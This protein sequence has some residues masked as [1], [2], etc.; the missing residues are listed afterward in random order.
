MDQKIKTTKKKM[1][2]NLNVTSLAT[3]FT[4]VLVTVLAGAMY[5]RKPFHIY[6]EQMRQEHHFLALPAWTYKIV[7]PLLIALDVSSLFLYFSYNYETCAQTYYIVA[8]AFALATLFGYMLWPIV[9]VKWGSATGGFLVLFW[10]FASASVVFGMMI[11]SM[12][13]TGCPAVSTV[14]PTGAI[15]TAFWG[16]Q[17][18]ETGPPGPK[19]GRAQVEK[20]T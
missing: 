3:W 9:F 2:S 1:W 7:W 20:M 10:S 11:A 16:V 18:G 5:M 19:W 4:T 12:L 13:N 17:I 14:Y 15:A 6:H 8:T